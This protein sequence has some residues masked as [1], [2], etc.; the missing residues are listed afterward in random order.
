MSDLFAEERY[1]DLAAHRASLVGP[2]VGI[3]HDPKNIPTSLEMA[4][5]RKSDPTAVQN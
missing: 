2:R 3:S 5:G 4:I 1:E